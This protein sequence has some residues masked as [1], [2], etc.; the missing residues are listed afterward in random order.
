MGS[1]KVERWL[2][3]GL[4]GGWLHPEPETAGAQI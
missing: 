2:L 4:P 3:A 1:M